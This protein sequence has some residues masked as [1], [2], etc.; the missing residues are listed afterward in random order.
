MSHTS[1]DNSAYLASELRRLSL[2]PQEAQLPQHDT[3]L[4]HDLLEIHHRRHTGQHYRKKRK[5]NSKSTIYPLQHKHST[6]ELPINELLSI[7]S[8]HNSSYNK[9]YINLSNEHK[10]MEKYRF[11]RRSR[12]KRDGQS[13]PCIHCHSSS[14]QLRDCFFP[15]QHMCVCRTCLKQL[16]NLQQCPLCNST[17][18]YVLCY[19]YFILFIWLAF[20]FGEY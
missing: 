5:K 16:P 3:K 14:R 4:K 11:H 18:R 10:R 15:C 8:K 19:S 6:G 13:P 9:D 1:P 12:R 20:D 17:I 2:G 7:E